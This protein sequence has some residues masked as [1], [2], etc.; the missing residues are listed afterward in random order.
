MRM[1][2]TASAV[3]AMLAACGGGGGG[4]D[5]A[6]TPAPVAGSPA[7]APGAAN[8]TPA[9]APAQTPVPAP[10]PPP[11]AVVTPPPPVGATPPPSAPPINEP[12]EGP[13]A[14]PP[15]PPSATSPPSA[16]APQT[17]PGA[18]LIQAL[19]TNY[20]RTMTSANPA[21]NFFSE[22][23]NAFGG[24]TFMQTSQFTPL[25]KAP[26]S[27][28]LTLDLRVGV[29]PGT[30]IFS[31]AGTV[32]YEGQLYNLVGPQ[33]AIPDQVPLNTEYLAEW[34]V[35]G[36]NNTVRFNIGGVGGHP[37][38]F[39]ACTDYNIAG[40]VRT[41]CFHFTRADGKPVGA[42]FIEQNAG[43]EFVHETN[44]DAEAPRRIHF[45]TMLET[46]SDP[47]NGRQDKTTYSYSIFQFKAPYLYINR[48]LTLELKPSTDF[49]IYTQ[50]DLGGG[51]LEES[52]ANP[53]GDQVFQHRGNEVT[54]WVQRFGFSG[55]GYN[56]SCQFQGY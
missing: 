25:D 9:P 14:P 17:I 7:P 41:S 38:Q 45:C 1:T 52:V 44:D 37:D 48:G 19:R 26:A 8:P 21:D 6:P 15:D 23:R 39:R 13:V 50:K 27:K 28:Q 29:G 56:K 47:V 3:A 16:P 34:K 40:L 42:D 33:Y 55:Y 46:T 32:Q 11:V 2:V 49:V 35:Q 18:V 10:V 4:G 36:T 20:A 31:G 12:V 30:W 51:L 53:R 24:Q 43:Q 54:K 22:L 5:V